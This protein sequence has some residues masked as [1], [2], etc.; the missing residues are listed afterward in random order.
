MET[1]PVQGLKYQK[2][3]RSQYRYIIK[4]IRDMVRH[5][6]HPESI[7]KKVQDSIASGNFDALVRL[8]NSFPLSFAHQDHRRLI[9]EYNGDNFSVQRFTVFDNNV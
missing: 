7:M 6:S 3:R 2:L 1:D 4:T 8:T 9:Q 5:I